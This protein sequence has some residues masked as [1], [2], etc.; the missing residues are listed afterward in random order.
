MRE[1]AI[2][3]VERHAAAAWPSVQSELLGDWKLRATYGVT[4]RANSV[5]TIGEPSP[6]WIKTTEHFYQKL[7]LSAIFMVSANSPSG[8]D[9]ELERNGYEKIDECYT[10]VK[11]AGILS[12]SD[13]HK[14]DILLI[15][16]ADDTWLHFFLSLEGFPNERASAYQA[17]FSRINGKKVFAVYR[18]AG[19]T[20]AVGTAVCE[21][22][23]CCIS[24]I[25]VDEKSRGKGIAKKLVS[26]LL[27]WGRALGAGYSYLQV[28]KSNAPAIGLYEKLGFTPLSSHH[29]RI[30]SE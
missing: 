25:V 27:E 20:L 14:G 13:L 22:D 11:E 19:L 6:G 23:L 26:S 12:P 10:M 15:D 16:E 3:E 21:G 1:L 5:L 9:E 2:E 17:I 8:I 29:Y 28:V 4:K 18:E 24:N 7:G 30:K